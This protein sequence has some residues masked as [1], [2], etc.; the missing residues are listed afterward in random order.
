MKLQDEIRDLNAQLNQ[1]EAQMEQVIQQKD[2]LQQQFRDQQQHG[3]E[4]SKR[5]EALNEEL[6]LREETI[7]MV[8]LSKAEV[9]AEKQHL[10]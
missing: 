8:K 2:K 5:N 9:E 1:N 7:Q 3:T 4:L 10:I 6:A